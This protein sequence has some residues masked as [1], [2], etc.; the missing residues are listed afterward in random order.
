LP[1]QNKLA[2]AAHQTHRAELFH[3]SNG[4]LPEK[5]LF[6]SNGYIADARVME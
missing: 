2:S 4:L 1:E 6:V 3:L 5:Y